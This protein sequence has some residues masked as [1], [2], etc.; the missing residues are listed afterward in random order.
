MEWVNKLD[1]IFIVS[2]QKRQERRDYIRKQF[3]ALGITARTWYAIELMNGAN[4]L[5]QTMKAMFQYCTDREFNQVGVFEDDSEFL[6][7]PELIGDCM[8][9]LPE[10]WLTFSPG[11]TLLT[12]PGTFSN[13]LLRVQAA[14]STHSVFYSLEAMKLILPLLDKPGPYDVLLKDH[15]QPL[16]Q[17]YCSRVLITTQKTYPSDI[18]KP[19][20]EELNNNPI[21]KQLYNSKDGS[22]NWNHI[23]QGSF[24]THTA[25]L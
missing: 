11:L 17:S 20:E 24:K 5:K 22:V 2:L 10:G 12:P 25:K 9:E 7:S 4:G 16:G 18:Y 19:T 23:I 13:N 1:E 21:M 3:K 6:V 14:Y 8:A 15:I